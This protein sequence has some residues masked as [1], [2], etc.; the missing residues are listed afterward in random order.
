MEKDEHIFE[1][2]RD[3]LIEKK[4]Y[5]MAETIISA[6]LQQRYDTAQNWLNSSLVS[7]KG[8]IGITSD[9]DPAQIRIGDGVTMWKDL[10][11]NT[12]AGIDVIRFEGVS[13]ANNA[14]GVININNV[15]ASKAV[16]AS[17]AETAAALTGVPKNAWT[18][19][20]ANYLVSE[21]FSVGSTT[22]GVFF[23]NGRPEKTAPMVTTASFNSWTGSASSKFAG[24][25]SYAINTPTASTAINAKNLVSTEN[26]I[27][28]PSSTKTV[29]VSGSILPGSAGLS[30]GSN[31]TSG[32]KWKCLNLD[33][34]GS[35]SWGTGTVFIGAKNGSLTVSTDEG[36]LVLYGDENVVIQDKS[37]IPSGTYTGATMDLGAETAPWS[38]LYLSENGQIDFYNS[39]FSIRCDGSNEVL[40]LGGPEI[41]FD[42]VHVVPSS[43]NSSSLGTNENRWASLFV[44][45]VY[46]YGDVIAAYSSDRRLKDNIQ[47]IS[48]EEADSVLQA[49]NPVSFEWNKI[50]EEL[51][52][53]HRKG[54]ARSFVADEFLQ[55][56]PNAGQKVYGEKYDAI[57]IE[58]VI[59]YLVAGY[60][61]QQQELEDLKKEIAELKK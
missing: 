45:N 49:L 18:A 16:T 29:I 6:S 10:P 9:T 31:S 20:V 14:G 38:N 39:M 46:A 43:S 33:G 2:A 7:K 28:N 30:I 1:Y 34:T 32:M 35:I 13:Y 4:I 55:V 3:R 56:L 41:A 48:S 58:Q 17:F 25:A 19:S 42:T 8:E 23:F 61:K 51:T 5:T 47:T 59:P 11:I 36:P 57:F 27:I 52:E 15:T 54:I 40:T 12:L 26:I 44:N 24:T 53:G 37:L 60:K 50:E 22:N 21:T